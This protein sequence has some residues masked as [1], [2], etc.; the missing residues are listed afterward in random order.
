MEDSI[1]SV[2]LNLR[3]GD[4]HRETLFFKMYDDAGNKIPMPLTGYTFRGKIRALI[5]GALLATF[6]MTITNAAL[7]EVER[8]LASAS[9]AALPSDSVHI[10]NYDCEWVAPNGDVETFVK[11]PVY[12]ELDV[13]Q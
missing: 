4:T 1:P 12:L 9:T 2:K 11:G 10:G 7:G 6:T 3:R 8:Y 5:D 13:P